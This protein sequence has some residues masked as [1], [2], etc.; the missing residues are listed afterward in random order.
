MTEKKRI[1][2]FMSSKGYHIEIET[3]LFESGTQDI[4]LWR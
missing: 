2:S 3:Y 4:P 1:I